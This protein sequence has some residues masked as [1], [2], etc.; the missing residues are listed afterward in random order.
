LFHK[1]GGAWAA[2]AGQFAQAYPAGLVKS[3]VRQVLFV[4]PDKV[5]V[6]DHLAA[7]GG[8][9]LPEVGWLLQVPEEPKVEFGNT[10]ASNG[11][12]WLRCRPLYPGPAIPAV[13]ATPVKTHR[14]SY[15]YKGGAA[16]VLVHLI[17][18]GDGKTPGGPAEAAVRRTAKGIELTLGGRTFMFGNR[19]PFAVA[20][21]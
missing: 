11:K 12:S 15:T 14:V 9:K 5:V 2:V 4:R 13:A 10:L 20:A 18:V 17:E 1:E 21:K 3:C 19:P 6:V 8:K 7:S 16:M